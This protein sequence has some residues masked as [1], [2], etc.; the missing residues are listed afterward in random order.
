MGQMIDDVRISVNGRQPV[1]FYGRAGGIIP[2][3]DE[4]IGEIKKIIGGM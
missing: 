2:G 4:V 3:P 1:Y